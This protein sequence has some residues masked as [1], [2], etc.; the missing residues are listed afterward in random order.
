MPKD[1]C[2]CCEVLKKQ[3]TPRLKVRTTKNFKTILSGINNT[4]E[5]MKKLRKTFNCCGKNTGREIIL[6]GD[7]SREVIQLFDTSPSLFLFCK[8]NV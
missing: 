4:E 2:V 3:R 1:A 8:Y 5:V 6:H 7:H